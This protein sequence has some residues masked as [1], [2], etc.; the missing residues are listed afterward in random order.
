MYTN[1]MCRFLLG[2]F[3]IVFTLLLLPQGSIAQTNTPT[4]GPILG[5]RQI[6]LP[7]ETCGRM[8]DPDDKNFTKKDVNR[9]CY[10]ESVY[11]KLPDVL[12]NPI[13][14]YNP[15]T[16]PP[17]AM[18]K[19]FWNGITGPIFDPI[20]TITKDSVKPCLS[21]TPSVKGNPEDPACYCVKDANAASTSTL[22]PLCR[23]IRNDKERF[24]CVG[25]MSKEG[26]IW[27][28]IGCIR[29]DFRR[30]VQETVLGYGVGIA[31]SLA[32]LCILYAAFSIQ[33]SRGNPEQIKKAQELLTSCIMGLLLIIFSVFILRIIGVN[34]LRLPGFS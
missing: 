19:I 21:G 31:G 13:I 29:G 2:I 23:N 26:G 14:K 7:G 15:I 22:L 11:P 33:T 4:L 25:C 1:H 5:P 17:L 30:F 9:C 28:G 32:L 12:S 8:F 20:N 3:F 27:S 18:F 6:P 34:L 24:N 10:W 16:G